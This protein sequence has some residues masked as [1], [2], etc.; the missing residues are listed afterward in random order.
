MD[1]E[2]LNKKKYQKTKSKISIVALIVFLIGV[3]IGGFLIGTG[4]KKQHEL[5]T[6]ETPAK[7]RVILQ[8]E[9][10]Q[11]NSD[12][13]SLKG[14][15]N[16]EF[17]ANGLSEEYYKMENEI[18]KLERRVLDLDSEIWNL[19]YSSSTSANTMKYIPFYVFGGFIIVLTLM[20]SGFIYTFAKRR[21]IFAFTAQQVMPVA[22]EGIEKM[23][24]SVGIAGN[25][26]M[27]NMAEG[28]GDIAKE[29]SKGIKEGLKEDDDK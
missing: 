16:A 14:K 28:I 18:R 4:M 2:L 23:A 26:V 6:D 7:T 9:I 8:N 11:V 3:S 1:E 29:V 27:K 12:M 10:D 19:K 15:Q 13:A 25:E 20:V 22:Q 5:N 21:E 24:P 17:K